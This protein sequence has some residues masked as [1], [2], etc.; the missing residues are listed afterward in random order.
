MF[1]RLATPLAACFLYYSFLLGFVDLDFPDHFYLLSVILSLSI[2]GQV[3]NL[4]I[5]STFRIT[6]HIKTA[7]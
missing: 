3:E 1:L 5:Y 6:G 2:S 4:L 7:L